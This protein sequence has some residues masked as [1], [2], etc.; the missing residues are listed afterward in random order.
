MFLQQANFPATI[1]VFVCFL[2]SVQFLSDI[3]L[4]S[5]VFKQIFF[6]VYYYSDILSCFVCSFFLPDV[7][8]PS[9]RFCLFFFLLDLFTFFL[10]ECFLFSFVCQFFYRMFLC[11]ANSSATV[12][13]TSR[14]SL[15][16]ALL[17]TQNVEL[18][19]Y[20]F[21]ISFISISHVCHVANQVS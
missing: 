12:D 6:I 2:S 15:K 21:Y 16:S 18:V 19:Q 20:Q 3:F 11:L 1:S 4:F 17:P 14:L 5:F 10:I 7:S 9:K 8:L 13:S